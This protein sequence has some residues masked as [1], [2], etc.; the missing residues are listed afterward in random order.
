ME[1]S[2]NL[3][4]PDDKEKEMRCIA[5]ERASMKN[6]GILEIREVIFLYAD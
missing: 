3:V 4:V 5:F 1:I 2:I 6:V